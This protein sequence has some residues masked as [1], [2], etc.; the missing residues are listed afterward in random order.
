MSEEVK[1][2]IQMVG[3]DELAIDDTCYQL[4]ANYKEG[5]QLE[6][7]SKR[8]CD[9][10]APYD[11][12]VGD[13]GYDQLR[14]KGFYRAKNQHAPKELRISTVQ[15]YLLEYCNFG[16]AYFILERTSGEPAIYHKPK[17]HRKAHHKNKKEYAEL[18]GNPK[19]QRRKKDYVIR[20]KDKDNV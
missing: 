19:N 16:C 6:A 3:F 8:Y 14:L 10:L 18:T 11:Y 12:I 2:Q 7:F 17:K 9:I 5:F 13:W 20:R 4:V 15:D 1:N